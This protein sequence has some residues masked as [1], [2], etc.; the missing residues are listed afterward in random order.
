[1]IFLQVDCT[2]WD[3]SYLQASVDLLSGLDPIVIPFFAG[4]LSLI[5]VRKLVLR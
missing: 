4:A 5:I 2:N 1:M 3:S